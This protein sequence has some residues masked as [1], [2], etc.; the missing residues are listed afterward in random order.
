MQLTGAYHSL[1]LDHHVYDLL[2]CNLMDRFVQQV[3]D[4]KKVSP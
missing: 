1:D 4:R 2:R 3:K